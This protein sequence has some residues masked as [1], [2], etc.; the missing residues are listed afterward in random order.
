VTEAKEEVTRRWFEELA[1]IVRGIRK[2][3]DQ[4]HDERTRADADNADALLLNLGNAM[5]EEIHRLEK[6][7]IVSREALKTAQVALLGH[8]K[9]N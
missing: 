8:E 2:R 6:K 1:T 7:L 3:A 5:G 4:N 9:S